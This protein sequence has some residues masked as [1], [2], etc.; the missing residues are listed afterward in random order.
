MGYSYRIFN[1]LLPQPYLCQLNFRENDIMS[2]TQDHRLKYFN[3]EFTSVHVFQNVKWQFSNQIHHLHADGLSVCVLWLVAL[4]MMIDHTDSQAVI[5]W[6]DLQFTI[7]TT[8]EDGWP[9]GDHLLQVR[10]A[11]S[12]SPVRKL[13]HQKV[14]ES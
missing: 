12:F 9:L 6:H 2:F 5:G 13:L 1:E 3:Y 14:W 11:V 8:R 4:A 10:N 7:E